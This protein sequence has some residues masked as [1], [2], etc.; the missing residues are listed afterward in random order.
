MA[1]Q[2]RKEKYE[3]RREIQRL[4]HEFVRA[5]DHLNELERQQLELAILTAV[6][7]GNRLAVVVAVEADGSHSATFFLDSYENPIAS[8]RV[9]LDGQN[10]HRDPTLVLEAGPIWPD[11]QP[12]PV[13]A[14]NLRELPEEAVDDPKPPWTQ[15]EVLD[16]PTTPDRP[17]AGAPGVTCWC[18][19]IHFP[20]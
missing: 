8:A 20:L 2:G 6:G 13:E 9:Y 4:V 5:T 16:D 1:Q 14:W 15:G 18:G 11:G 19:E 3:R 10:P 12:S 7:L 17:H